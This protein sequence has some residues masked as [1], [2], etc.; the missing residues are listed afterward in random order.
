MNSMY[1]SLNGI[2]TGDG[3]MAGGLVGTAFLQQLLW[4]LCVAVVGPINR[5]N[6]LHRL[7]CKEVCFVACPSQTSGCW[8]ISEGFDTPYQQLEQFL[9]TERI[10]PARLSVK[11]EPHGRMTYTVCQRH[12]N[13]Y[14]ATINSIQTSL[15][16][17]V[18]LNI[19]SSKTGHWARPWP[20]PT[21][22]AH[23]PGPPDPP[24]SLCICCDFCWP[25]SRSRTINTLSDPTDHI[26]ISELMFTLQRVL[27][28]CQSNWS[29]MTRGPF[30]ARFC[31]CLYSQ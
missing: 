16:S 11:P 7:I 30:N 26:H 24:L 2:L 31:I 29:E 28:L 5:S 22:E 25:T 9:T 10:T 18:G 12:Q 1:S 13:V 14:T 4:D 27:F 3:V 6:A 19:N 21:D 17:E 20:R 8:A 23:C 15:K